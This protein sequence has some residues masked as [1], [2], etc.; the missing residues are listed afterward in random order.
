MFKKLKRKIN[1]FWVAVIL[2]TIPT[3]FTLLR[4]GFF[5]MQDDLQAFRVHQMDKCFQDLQFPCR[6]VPD[7]GYQYGY[8]L[9]NYYPPS[10]YY[11]GELI[12][13]LGFQF[14]DSVKILFILGFL[15]SS[16]FMFLLLRSFLNNWAALVGTMLYTYAPYKAVEVYV[17]GA[18]SEFWS[19]SLFPFLFW[20]SLRLVQTKK[21]IY[22]LWFSLGLFLL[23][24]THNLMSLIFLPVLGIW[25]LSWIILEKKWKLSLKFILG[26]LLGLGMAA[27]F[28]LPIAFERQYAHLETLLGGY[29]GYEQHF[30]DIKQLLISNKFGYGSSFIGP[31]DDL[32]IS[33][34]PVQVFVAVFALLISIYALRKKSKLAILVIILFIVEIIILFMIHPRS[35]FIWKVIKPLEWLQFPWR[36]LADSIFVIAIIGAVGVFLIKHKKASYIFGS[37]IMVVVILMNISFFKPMN[38]INISDKEKFSGNLWEKQLTI[39]I[40][41]YLPI[42]AKL[43]PIKKAPEYPE[44]LI[45]EI[46]F[47]KYEKGSN[48][49]IGDLDVKKDSTIRL[50]L[51]DFPGMEVKVDGEKQ[52]HINNNCKDQEFCLGLIT[53]DIPKGLHKVETRLTDTPIRTLGNSLTITSILIWVTVYLRNVKS[54]RDLKK[55]AK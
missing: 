9:F 10:V 53:F 25:I 38:W 35:I 15:T 49:Q 5:Y 29:F 28:S 18:M 36:F 26:G 13:L 42:Y 17:R 30:A 20:A 46:E 33:T 23:L 6:W 34:G 37:A 1:Y 7:P 44:V 2:L 51:F 40:F 3:F 43:P 8:P 48:Y 47:L 11:L 24:I 55:S 22:L 54:A 21:K 32:S 27:F 41:D 45:G 19:L 14:I 39:S 50:P 52:P 31:N 12:H 16:I 4:P